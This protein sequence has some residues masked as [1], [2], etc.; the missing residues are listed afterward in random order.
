MAVRPRSA[1]RVPLGQH[2]A[3]QPETAL[4]GTYHAIDHAKYAHRY[5][6]EFPY[7]FNRRC[8]LPAMAPLLLRAAVTTKPHPR[9]VLMVSESISESSN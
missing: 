9:R 8:D 7:R 3:R 2:D 6:A 1:P 4:K 5:L